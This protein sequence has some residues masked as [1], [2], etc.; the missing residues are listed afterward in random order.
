MHP[1]VRLLRQDLSSIYFPRSSIARQVRYNSSD[2]F[3]ER[4]RRRLW[5][6]D[7]PPGLK[8]PY[9]GQGVLERRWS[10][11]QQP[12]EAEEAD[13][14]VDIAPPEDYVEAK[15]WDGLQR[16]GHLGKWS[17]L[18][19][20]KEDTYKP[21]LPERKFSK[22]SKV[23]PAAH[24]AAVEISMMRMLKK[25]LTNICDVTDHDPAILEM[26]MACRIQPSD[27]WKSTIKFPDQR[28]KEALIYVFDQLGPQAKKQKAKEANEENAEVESEIDGKLKQEYNTTR[29]GGSQALALKNPLIK[30]AFLKRFSQLTGQR[31]SDSLISSATRVKHLVEY[32]DKKGEQAPKKLAV[33]LAE[34]STLQ[35]LPNVK[36]FKER[37]TPAHKDREVGRW[38]LIDA[39]LRERGLVT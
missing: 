6:T 13:H 15:T 14:D 5:G 38:K 37:Q 18:P 17:D 19:P 30:F 26:I 39:E 25:P 22:S 36:I 27:S 24:Q 12:E 20:R 21:F 33:T 4:V 16:I 1:S 10:G 23:A 9:G 11:R 8:D 29:K 3:S 2:K 34:S 35:K 32:L 7:N 28:T 31:L